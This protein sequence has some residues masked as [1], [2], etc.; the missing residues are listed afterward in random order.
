MKIFEKLIN[1]HS[2]VKN[3]IEEN[4]YVKIEVRKEEWNPNVKKISYPSIVIRAG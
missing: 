3:E 1:K 2:G 4:I